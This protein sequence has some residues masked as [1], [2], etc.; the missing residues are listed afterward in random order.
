MTS[1]PSSQ[2]NTTFLRFPDHSKTKDIFK[3]YQR[4][5]YKIESGIFTKAKPWAQ[6]METR[7]T[8]AVP[9]KVPAG[10]LYQLPDP[11]KEKPGDEEFGLEFSDVKENSVKRR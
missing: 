9:V 11:F 4:F 6:T 5:P 8:A 7:P 1:T 3:N 2:F 10:G